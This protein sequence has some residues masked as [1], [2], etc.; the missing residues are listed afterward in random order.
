MTNI[1]ETKNVDNSNLIEENSENQSSNKLL[2]GEYLLTPL[3]VLILNK[4]LPPGFKL[5][6]EEIYLKTAADIHKETTNM[7]GKK[8]KKKV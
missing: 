4:K 7:I 2:N 3:Q 6:L 5:E 8:R 1:E